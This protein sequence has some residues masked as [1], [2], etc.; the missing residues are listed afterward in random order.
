MGRFENVLF[1]ACI[2]F[3]RIDLKTLLFIFFFFSFSLL[4]RKDKHHYFQ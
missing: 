1:L 3:P 4:I 2:F